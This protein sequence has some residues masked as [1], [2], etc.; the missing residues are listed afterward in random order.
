MK[1]LLFAAVIVLTPFI[2]RAQYFWDFGVGVGGSNYLGEMG[3][4]QLTRRDFV[5]DIKM[6]ETRQAV[7]GFARYK[8]SPQFSI[9]GNL[10]YACIRGA[11]SLCTNEPRYWRNLNFRNQMFELSAECQYFFYEINDLG[12]TYRYRNNFRAYI[13]LGIGGLYHNPKGNFNGTWIALRPLET[14]NV[15]YTKVTLTIPA[16]AGFYFTVN[17]HY[18]IGWCIDWRT[19]FSDYLDDASTFYVQNTVPG[20]A[21]VADRT[22]H[23]AANAWGAQ[24]SNPGFGNNFGYQTWTDSDGNVHLNKRGDP[25]HNDSFITTSVE[26][27]YVIRGKS[28]IYKSHYSY[29]FKGKKYKHRKVRAK[30]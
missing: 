20:A 9:K 7:N 15:R 14:E 21:A 29:M 22:N 11:D 18:R 3:G 27:S 4:K 2:A 8:I 24:N 10:S 17:K 13:G 5:M 26:F 1:K 19:T 25:T 16:T 28:S 30:F 23:A 6:K 12:H